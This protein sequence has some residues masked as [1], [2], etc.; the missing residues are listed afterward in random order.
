M[1]NALV[2]GKPLTQSQ[3]TAEIGGDKSRHREA[4]AELEER[5]EIEVTVGGRTKWIGRAAHEEVD[6]GHL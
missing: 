2:E 3:L 5:G 6:D 4:I 1:L